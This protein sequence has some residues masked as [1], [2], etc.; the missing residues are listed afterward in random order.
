MAPVEAPVDLAALRRHATAL[1][2]STPGIPPSVLGEQQRFTAGLEMSGLRTQVS[3]LHAGLAAIQAKSEE[4]FE[5]FIV[6]EGKFGKSTLVNALL[7][8]P[9]APTDFLPKTW[10][11]NRYVAQ[12][13]PAPHVRVFVD[14]K[15]LDDIHDVRTREVRQALRRRYGTF[16]GLDEYHVSPADAQ[17]I[18]AAEEKRVAE[19]LGRSDAYWSPIMEMEWSVEAGHSLVPEVRIVDTMGINQQLAPASHKHHLKWQYERADAVFWIVTAD[20]IGAQST[21]DELLE[22]GRYA[23]L[24]FLLLTKMDTIS[25]KAGAIKR[26]QKHYGDAVSAIIPVSG[27]AAFLARVP[28]EYQKSQAEKG[29]LR[30]HGHPS[31]DALL[32]MSGFAELETYLQQFLGRRRA[33]SRNL[34]VYSALRAKAREFRAIAAVARQDAAANKALFLELTRRTEK[35]Q[36]ER[37]QATNAEVTA[38]LRQALASVEG[39]IASTTWENRAFVTGRLGL[40][41]IHNDISALSGNRATEAT[42][43][44]RDTTLTWAASQ[45]TGYIASEF[46]P[47]GRVA[48][49]IRTTALTTIDIRVACTIYWNIPNVNDFLRDLWTN[50]LVCLS[51]IPIL[52]TIFADDANTAQRDATCAIQNAL[53]EA[54]PTQISYLCEQVQNDLLSSIES[55]GT[56]LLN[57][58]AQQYAKVGGDA[59]Q[60]MALSSIDSAMAQPLVDPLVV[61]LPMRTMKRMRWECALR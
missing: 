20:K 16:R 6:G 57:D 32:A 1:F 17:R 5:L 56:A 30:D 7:G 15:L 49:R 45:G 37:T 33:Y 8:L 2:G 31:A 58:I 4:P 19:T 54:I 11:F 3:H 28:T 12:R 43:L 35:A 29:W 26:A 23:K 42:R 51:K 44:Y 25:N 52:G 21:R 46:S 27:L 40:S 50:G 59:A 61:A 53:R 39:A 22:A 41:K 14:P 34:Q 36:H 60:D 48:E 18:A 24:V 55:T 47:T 38:F 13:T 10:C 9:A